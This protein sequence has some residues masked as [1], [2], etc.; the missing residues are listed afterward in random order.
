MIPAQYRYDTP[1]SVNASAG[2]EQ[3]EIPIG[4]NLTFLVESVRREYRSANLVLHDLGGALLVLFTLSLLLL[5]V[6]TLYFMYTFQRNQ[7][8]RH[9]YMLHL[10]ELKDFVRQV[11]RLKE[12]VEQ[13]QVIVNQEKGEIDE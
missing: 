11:P 5:P 4:L 2:Q 7:V 1:R 6:I 13:E 9:E 10:M 3:F 12:I 8:L